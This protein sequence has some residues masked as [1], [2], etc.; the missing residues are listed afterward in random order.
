MTKMKTARKLQTRLY[1]RLVALFEYFGFTIHIPKA[2]TPSTIPQQ[3]STPTARLL[4]MNL[5]EEVTDDVL[6]VLFQQ[7]VLIILYRLSCFLS[8]SRHPGLQSIQVA[9]SPTPNATV[10]RVKMAQVVYENS[11]LATAAKNGLDGFLLKKDW[12]MSVSYI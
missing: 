9:W 4:C 2:E 3:V 5:P 10:P 8:Y 12:Q 1:V 11:D 7:Y 6:S